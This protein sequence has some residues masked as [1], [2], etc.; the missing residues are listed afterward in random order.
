MAEEGREVHPEE[1][2]DIKE[3]L[4]EIES[5]RADLEKSSTDARNAIRVE[6]L[7]K[8]KTLA[9]EVIETSKSDPE[10]TKEIMDCLESITIDSSPE[11]IAKQIENLKNNKPWYSLGKMYDSVCKSIKSLFSSSPDSMNESKVRDGALD[12]LKQA[13]DSGDKTKINEA[14]DEYKQSVED[15]Q[16]KLEEKGSKDGS[17][18]K[19]EAQDN[20][21]WKWKLALFILACGSLVGALFL[22]SSLLTGCYQYKNGQTPL[23]LNSCN[24]FYKKDQNQSFCSCGIPQNPPD[25]KDKDQN[26]PFCQC[27]DVKDQICKDGSIYYAYKECNPFTLITDLSKFVI[28]NIE[29]AGDILGQL[30]DFLKKWGYVFLIAIGVIIIVWVGFKLMGS[31]EDKDVHIKIDK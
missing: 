4:A 17:K 12:K 13:M 8:A 23:Q 31:S 2:P 16:E 26:Y 18:E 29:K 6:L 15:L 3:S 28:D 20:G 10:K 7:D 22:I 9:K 21:S 24:D 19:I 11:N 27:P 30:L 1:V 5:L 14:F 25:C